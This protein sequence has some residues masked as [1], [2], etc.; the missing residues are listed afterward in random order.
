[1]VSV[2]QVYNAVKNIA[3]KEQK[4]FITPAIFNSFA[5]IAQMSIY[6]EMFLE[7]VDAKRISRQNFD[8]GRDKSVRKQ[9][10]EDLAFYKRRSTME[11]TNDDLFQKPDDLSK[12]IS[13]TVGASISEM[14]G[15]V[16][17]RINCELV[18]DPE[19]LD[20]I[21]NSLLSSP[22]ANFPVALIG[23]NDIEIIPNDVSSAVLNYYAKPTSFVSGGG[24]SDQPPFY[25]VLNITSPG[26]E[27]VELP[28]ISSCR[29]FMLPTHY[30]NE[31]ISEILKLIGVRLRDGSVA[32]FATQEEASE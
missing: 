30:L 19:K 29:D 32:A 28:D 17:E 22:T 5:A 4:G 25:T 1:M 13:I 31:I 26:G 14:T 3:N 6:N 24:I 7:L 10:L 8:P 18:Y 9:K 20:R 2:V 11:V 12:I 16:D 23:T 27:V 21:V 15:T